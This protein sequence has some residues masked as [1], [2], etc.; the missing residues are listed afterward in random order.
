M[1]TEFQEQLDIYKRACQILGARTIASMTEDSVAAQELN[2]SYGKL[3]DAELRRN[4]W[5]FATRRSIIRPVNA[6]TAL[7]TPDAWLAATTY[8]AG[9]TV[10]HTPANLTSFSPAV[11]FFWEIDQHITGNSS[12]SE[13][14]VDLKWHRFFGP[15]TFDPFIGSAAT[16]PA[17]PVLSQT[18][19]GSLAQRKY[20]VVLTYVTTSGETLVGPEASITVSAN[21][22]LVVTSPAASTGATNYHVY[23]GTTAGEET[24]QTITASTVNIGS[25]WTEPTTGLIVGRGPPIAPV[26]STNQGYFNGELTIHDNIVYRSLQSGNNDVPPSQKW[27]A[28]GG[29]WRP[30]SILYPIGA[31]PSTDTTTRNAYRL[32]EGFLKRANEDPRSDATH[33]LGAPTGQRETDWV[34]EAGFLVSKLSEP[35]MV[36]FVADITDVQDMDPMFCEGLAARVGEENCLRLT[37]SIEKKNLATAAYKNAMSEARLTN[38]ILMGSQAAELDGYI[39]CRL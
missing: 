21:N 11:G 1:Q 28:V 5:V 17:A 39:A 4:T 19:G 6:S 15:R 10:S 30:F 14:S 32:P 8:E 35:I 16:A 29:T 38:S 31:G 9:A 12:N 27:L 33:W 36:R 22:L 37:G 25:N 23:V 2:F 20:Y 26:A 34:F 24:L 18:A 7:W 3:R 13:P